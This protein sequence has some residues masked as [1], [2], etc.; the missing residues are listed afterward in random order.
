MPSRGFDPGVDT[1]QEPPADG[2]KV[3]L[4]VD[5]KS[6]RLQILS[7]FEKWNGKDLEDLAVLI[8]VVTFVFI[9]S[10]FYRTPIIT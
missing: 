7:P 10:Q 1:Y 5:P 9:R 8:K 2:S 6:Q 3:H 4:A